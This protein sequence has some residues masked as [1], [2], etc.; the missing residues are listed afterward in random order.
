MFGEKNS[1][2]MVD[3][4]PVPNVYRLGRGAFA[5]MNPFTM[6]ASIGTY[7]AETGYQANFG[8][9]TKFLQCIAVHTNND[10]CC[11]CCESWR[12]EG[13]VTASENEHLHN[14]YIRC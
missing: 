9:S 2:T 5:T 11:E 3:E 12:R 6:F 8:A 7:M 14:S 10:K 4:T 1:T 13:V